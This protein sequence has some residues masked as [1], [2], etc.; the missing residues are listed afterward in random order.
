MPSTGGASGE[1]S[2]PLPCQASRGNAERVAQAGAGPPVVTARAALELLFCSQACLGPPQ[3]LLERTLALCEWCGRGTPGGRVAELL[4]PPHGL[5]PAGLTVFP[6]PGA[7]LLP[8]SKG[9]GQW[10]Q[11][12]ARTHIGSLGEAGGIGAQNSSRALHPPRICPDQNHAGLPCPWASGHPRSWCKIQNP[13]RAPSSGLGAVLL[14]PCCSQAA[15]DLL[16]RGQDFRPHSSLLRWLLRL[17][18]FYR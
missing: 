7:Y 5:P 3:V 16:T 14:S 2:G 10:G 15:A 9:E 8:A 18:L 17:F 6:V 13:G 4:C 1:A 12:G 11:R